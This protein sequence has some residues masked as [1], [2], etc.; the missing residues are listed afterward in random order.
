MS[1]VSK[2]YRLMERKGVW[3]YRRMMPRHLIPVFGKKVIQGIVR[4]K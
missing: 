3:Y 1:K 2:K 4:G